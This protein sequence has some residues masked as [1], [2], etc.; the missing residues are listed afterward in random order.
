MTEN[1]QI[2]V[3]IDNPGKANLLAQTLGLSVLSNQAY[4]LS[5]QMYNALV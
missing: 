3:G 4:F 1:P 5:I 2:I